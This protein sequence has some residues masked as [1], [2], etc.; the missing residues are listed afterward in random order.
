LLAETGTYKISDV[1]AE[2][3]KV[4]LNEKAVGLVPLDNPNV[5][6]A[7]LDKVIREGVKVEELAKIDP[8]PVIKAPEVVKKAPVTVAA[9]KKPYKKPEA[10]I[11]SKPRP[12]ISVPAVPATKK[13]APVAKAAA[14]AVAPVV[15]DKSK[16]E[17]VA[18]ILEEDDLR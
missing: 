13:V 11:E 12:S 9:P 15:E 17:F 10:K 6:F 1:A 18:N 2:F 4:E 14:P 3:N 5:P 7:A 16:K 8:H